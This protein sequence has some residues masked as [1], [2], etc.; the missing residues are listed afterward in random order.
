M[1]I[2]RNGQRGKGA[3]LTIDWAYADGD[4]EKIEIVEFEN[5]CLM[6]RLPACL[7]RTTASPLP[8]RWTALRR[9]TPMVYRRRDNR[10]VVY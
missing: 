6:P 8:R 5:V 2:N 10:L 4:T 3:Q 9:I 1:P 7:Q